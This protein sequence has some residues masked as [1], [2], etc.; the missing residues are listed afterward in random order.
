[1]WIG[2]ALP[3][4]LAELAVGRSVIAAG[5]FAELSPLEL[6]LRLSRGCSSAPVPA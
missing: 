2:T 4:R 5:A 6:V 3:W 1:M